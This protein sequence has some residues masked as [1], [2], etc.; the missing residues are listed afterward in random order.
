M[1][2]ESINKV[3]KKHPKLASKREKLEQMQDG[4]YCM[5]GS[6]GFGRI[7][8][9]DENSGKLVI[10]FEGMPGHMMD[11]AFCADKEPPANKAKQTA[12]TNF[13][14]IQSF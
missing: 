14:I 2:S 6:W 11:P 7:K 5:H 9:Y 8:S 4:A 1:N 13:F 3:I 10:D 12:I